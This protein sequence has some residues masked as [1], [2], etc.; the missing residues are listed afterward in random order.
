MSHNLFLKLWKNFFN[1]IPVIKNPATKKYIE[2][3]SKNQIA[4]S[5]LYNATNK[6]FVSYESEEVILAKYQ[7]AKQYTGM[8]IM[9]W[10]YT[11]DT[12]D[13]YVN[14]IYDAIN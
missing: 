5:Y 3:N 4:G 7:F 8:G 14:T 10:A 11:E 13:R 12:A 6:I 1:N 9:C 2:Y